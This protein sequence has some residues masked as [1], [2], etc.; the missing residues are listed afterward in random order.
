M[1]ESLWS[2][3]EW[4]S[5]EVTIP[6]DSVFI[7]IMTQDRLRPA[8][9]LFLLSVVPFLPA[10]KADYLNWDD[11]IYY[12]E[13]P[14]IDSPGGWKDYLGHFT[15]DANVYPLVFL[16]FKIEDSLFGK[17]PEISHAIN[18]ILHGLVTVSAFFLLRS[19][20]SDWR[21][22][23]WAALLFAIHPLQVSTVAWVTERKSLLGS[24]F[25][26]IALITALLRRGS[27]SAWWSLPMAVGAYMC[28]SPLVVFPA[29]L[30]V[31]GSTIS[32]NSLSK[33]RGT[34]TISSPSPEGGDGA[35]GRGFWLLPGL[36]LVIAA[37]FAWIY[38]VR[39]VSQSLSFSEK[40][41]LVPKTLWHYLSKWA[42]PSELLP[43]YSR[44][45][46]TGESFPFLGWIPI[47]AVLILALAFRKQIDRME[48]FGGIFFAV[49]LL[50][51][52]G[53]VSFG[54]QKHS[55]VSD[56]F[57]YL[58]TLGL[59][60]VLSSL[61]TRISIGRKFFFPSICTL[62]VVLWSLLSWQQCRVWQSPPTFWGAVL[63]SDSESWIAHQNLG[64]YLDA[65]GEIDEAYSHYQQATEIDPEEPIGW[66][67][68]GRS[69]IL[70]SRYEEATHALAKAIDLNVYYVE[71]HLFRAEAFLRMGEE[72]KAVD[73]L[74][75]AIAVRSGHVEARLKIADLLLHAEATEVRNP[76][77]ALRWLRPFENAPP[78]QPVLSAWKLLAEAHAVKGDFDQAIELENRRLEALEDPD[79]DE[80]RE[81]L[82][83]ISFYK[84][85]QSPWAF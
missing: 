63:E 30:L 20:V 65:E 32:S 4:P 28:K 68:L 82:R 69:L 3:L 33:T 1:Q 44:W 39:E 60:I 83:R 26:L 35:R 34:E 64:T 76:K 55:F 23:F 81:T 12:T 48:W 78:T 15:E 22:A 27:W 37:G 85:G 52:V 71:A 46:L 62:L 51:A 59:S 41:E 13:N 21:I 74:H 53:L 67:N 16:S 54:Y 84:R 18:L 10:L 40:L 50:P 80:Y 66:I 5:L 9:L 42:M 43:I 73:Q 17:N 61:M 7:P 57:M 45:D 79:S 72:Q 6:A 58:P 77:Q 14:A 11:D 29:I 19:W 38:S 8:I 31:A 36:H 75:S 49:T 25:F 24:F 47:L 56:H 2:F 70:Q